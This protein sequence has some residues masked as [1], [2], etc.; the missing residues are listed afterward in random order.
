MHNKKPV[1]H[2][3]IPGFCI[4]I[5]IDY[6]W[7]GLSFAYGKPYHRS[8]HNESARL[9][10]WNTISSGRLRTHM[11]QREAG[12]AQLRL[13]GFSKWLGKTWQTVCSLLWK[14]HWR[15][16][17]HWEWDKQTKIR[18]SLWILGFVTKEM[19]INILLMIFFSQLNSSIKI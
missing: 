1:Y 11:H 14:T 5:L 6:I 9:L 18:I 16:A 4:H 10:L 8:W 17:V 13:Q 2:F 19:C 12:K 3:Y 7:M 15:R